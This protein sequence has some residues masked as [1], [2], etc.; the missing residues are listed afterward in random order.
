MQYINNFRKERDTVITITIS[1]NFIF[2]ETF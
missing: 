2:F 1:S